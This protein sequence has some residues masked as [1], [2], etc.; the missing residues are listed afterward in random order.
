MIPVRQSTAFECPIGPILDADGVAVTN[1]VVGDLK[2]KKTTGN[3]A[4]LNGS[5]TLTHVSAGVYD[6]VLTTSDTDTVGLLTVAIDDTVNACA[7]LHLQVM[8]EVIYDALYAASANTFTG[9]AG[10]TK[11][12]GV[13]LTDTLTTYTGNTPQTGD[14]FA[15]IG[16]T[17]SGLTSLAQ[18]AVLGA[19]A[20]AAADGA[21]TT[22]D[23]VVAYLKQL[24]NTLEGAPGMPTWPAAAAPGNNV[25]IAEALRYLYDQV[26]VAG[27][28]LTAAD[29]AVITA[30]GTLQTS[31]DDLPTNAELATSQAAADDATLAAIAALNNLSAAQVNAEVDT[32]LSDYGALKPTTA[33]RTLDVTA[34]GNAGI[35]WANIEAPTTAVNLSATNID[36]DQVVASVSGAVGSVT[37]NVGGSVASVLGDVGGSVIGDVEGD[38]FGDV[39]GNVDGKV[40]GGGAGTI[41]GTGVRAVDSS[42]NAIPTAA[43]NAAASLDV[44]ASGTIGATGNTTSILHLDGLAWADDGPNNLLVRFTDV[45]TGLKYSRWIE[46]FATTGDLA[47]LHS[48]LPVTPEAS[49]D[50]YVVLAVRRDVTASVALSQDDIDDIVEGVSDGLDVPTVDE[51]VDGLADS[52]LTVHSPVVGGTITLMVGCDYTLAQ[53][54]GVRITLPA[55]AYEDITGATC[56]LGVT[57]L[58]DNTGGFTIEASAQDG[59]ASLAQTIDFEP[60]HA[61]DETGVLDPAH[62]YRANVLI[63]YAGDVRVQGPEYKVALKVNR[64][65]V[66]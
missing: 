55:E 56:Y 45:S 30:V 64:V 20:D 15:R 7:S 49:V 44:V 34:G 60:S 31:V 23:T 24:I 59:D 62:E 12:S 42:G 21:V 27:A 46:D 57:K 61:A 33:G 17:G 1:G 63:V 36:I 37:G 13:V 18:A 25:S 26:G 22:T 9:S 29:D 65:T 47:T 6:L 40:L 52:D 3:F 16:A 5:A 58:N 32:A 4:A 51:I 14:S 8:E 39:G 53:G 10:S 54:F 2:L 11:V 66:P 50:T 19:L 48:A 41:T 43:Q 38:V 28:G 35:D